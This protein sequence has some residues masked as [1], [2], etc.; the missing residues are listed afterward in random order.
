[1]KKAYYLITVK[2]ANGTLLSAVRKL[3]EENIDLLWNT[4]EM[5]ASGVYRELEYFNLVLL[6]RYS[7]EVIE[8]EKRKNNP[9]HKPEV[10]IIPAR[11]SKREVKGIGPTLLERMRANQPPY[12]EGTDPERA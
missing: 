3:E 6:S 5:K 1:M 9:G 2:P 4:Y 7:R 12:E 11:K 10:D 8:Y